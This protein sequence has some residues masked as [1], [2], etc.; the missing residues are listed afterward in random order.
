[1][2]SACSLLCWQISINSCITCIK[3]FCSNVH[4]FKY[5]KEHYF[6]L[7]GQFWSSGSASKGKQENTVVVEPFLRANK[8]VL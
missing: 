8:D 3:S 7:S 2:M 6:M 5:S 4:V 1:M